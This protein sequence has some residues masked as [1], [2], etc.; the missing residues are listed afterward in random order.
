MDHLPRF[1]LNTSGSC[2]LPGADRPA[3]S[4][5]VGP[6]SQDANGGPS[7]F[8][9]GVNEGGCVLLPGFAGP[10]AGEPGGYG[11][12][13]P[14]DCGPAAFQSVFCLVF[15]SSLREMELPVAVLPAPR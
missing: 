1:A 11:L 9:A 8:R 14:K 6:W 5:A 3:G 4:S 2:E 13:R 12:G 15:R 10:Q 7:R